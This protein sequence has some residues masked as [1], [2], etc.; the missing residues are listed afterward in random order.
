M[1]PSNPSIVDSFTALHITRRPAQSSGLLLLVDDVLQ[2]IVEICVEGDSPVLGLHA[3]WIRLSWVCQRLRNVVLSMRK[4]HAEQYTAYPGAQTAFKSRAGDVP[5]WYHLTPSRPRMPP[6]PFLVDTKERRRMSKIRQSTDF[7]SCSQIWLIKRGDVIEHL[8]RL[9][10]YPS[11]TSLEE[12]RIAVEYEQQSASSFMRDVNHP[13]FT[14]QLW[15]P[16]LLRAYFE[17]CWLPM[18]AY[19]LRVLCI[20]WDDDANTP[21]PHALAIHSALVTRH[22][23]TLEVLELRDCLLS[24]PARITVAQTLAAPSLARVP[25]PCL[26][27]LVLTG[28][29]LSYVRLLGALVIP[30]TAVV[31]LGV[32]CELLPDLRATLPMVMQ[33]LMDRLPVPTTAVNTVR[34]M[35]QQS[36]D[37]LLDLVVSGA[38][39][40]SHKIRSGDWHR[41]SAPEPEVSVSLLGVDT[42]Q[43]DWS[44][45]VIPILRKLESGLD[46]EGVAFDLPDWCFTDDEVKWEELFASLPGVR[47]VRPLERIVDTI[48]DSEVPGLVSLC[49]RLA[50]CE[51]TS[52]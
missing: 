5:L 12:I 27:R 2:Y 13:S 40:A 39:V 22:R 30:P 7:A 23:A 19:A 43:V 11:L 31:Q 50:G 35:V 38:A 3:G 21:R 47:T 20:D 18:T 10:L 26:R 51:D 28:C 33:V 42:E 29:T 15:A 9:I 44:G 45:E 34:I 6:V 37:G 32:D 16:H 1:S 14:G 52:K 4:L 25:L 41:Q 24:P 49:H 36:D 48:I 17:S 46:V 8:R